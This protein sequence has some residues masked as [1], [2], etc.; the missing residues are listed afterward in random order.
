[1]R[2]IGEVIVEKY[3]NCLMELV[4]DGLDLDEILDC[5]DLPRFD[6]LWMEK[7]KL[8]SE[9]MKISPLS[10]EERF[11]ID[12]VRKFAFKCVYNQTHSSDL[13]ACASDDLELIL[14]F[15]ALNIY[16]IFIENLS[17]TYLDKK[18]PY[19]IS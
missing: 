13:S 11:K 9:K 2:K 4:W 16:D 6:N 7:Y 14:N 12:I 8:I 19:I 3:Q 15:Y 17:N 10:V 18:F 5:R 1:M